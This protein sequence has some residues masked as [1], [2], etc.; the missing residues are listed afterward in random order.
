[1][2]HSGIISFHFSSIFMPG[3]LQSALLMCLLIVEVSLYQVSKRWWPISKDCG[4]SLCCLWLDIMKRNG[5]YK[6]T[7]SALTVIALDFWGLSQWLCGSL[8]PDRTQHSCYL[9]CFL[10]SGLPPSLIS[11]QYSA[12]AHGPLP[13]NRGA[14]RSKDCSLITCTKP[15]SGCFT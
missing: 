5:R 3:T 10:A 11:I 14:L 6:G 4:S 9:C 12:G 2:S 8:W 13:I 7:H 1:M 15:T